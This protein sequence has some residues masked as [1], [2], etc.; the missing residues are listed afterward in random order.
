MT[1]PAIQQTKSFTLNGEPLLVSV[2]YRGYGRAGYILPVFLYGWR[3]SSISPRSGG[4]QPEH[5]IE[6][7]FGSL[8]A[9]LVLAAHIA[10]SYFLGMFYFAVKPV[11]ALRIPQN[12]RIAMV[13][14]KAPSTILHCR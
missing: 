1:R 13:V 11:G 8:V 14:T 6:G 3:P 4:L 12:N 9:T 7:V 5:R 2:F 10:A